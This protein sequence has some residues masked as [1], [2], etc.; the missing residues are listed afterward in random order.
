MET[1]SVLFWFVS[2]SILLFIF[3]FQSQLAIWIIMFGKQ[4]Y[5]II[6]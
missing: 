1:L 6:T 4:Y 3:A 2:P 5:A